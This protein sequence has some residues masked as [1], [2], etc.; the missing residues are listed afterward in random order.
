MKK[1]K[2][3]II[4]LGVSIAILGIAG[5]GLWLTNHLELA[6]AVAAFVFALTAFA[7]GN[8]WASMLMRSGAEL[9]IRSQESDD[10]R[11]IAQI[12]AATDLVKVLIRQSPTQPA[13]PMPSKQD[14]WRCDF[15]D[16]D[17]TEVN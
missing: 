5:A 8:V 13:L 4:C 1:M 9:T 11:D 16:G 7:V 6:I 15:E 10:E 14:N 3:A 17:Y 2:W 12:K